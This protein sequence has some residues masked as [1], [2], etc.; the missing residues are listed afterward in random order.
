MNQKVLKWKLEEWLLFALD[1]AKYVYR[2]AKIYNENKDYEWITLNVWMHDYV[3]EWK[4]PLYYLSIDSL[5]FAERHFNM[6]LI[7]NSKLPYFS[8]W[9]I[10]GLL[11]FYHKIC[12][13][14]WCPG[15]HRSNLHSRILLY[16]KKIK[17][18]ENNENIEDNASQDHEMLNTMEAT[19]D[20]CYSPWKRVENA[21]LFF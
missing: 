21:K 8:F 18:S 14:E 15:N 13:N 1:Y 10:I 19:T 6:T 2:N 5:K 20:F 4:I 12:I 11:A 16:T 9:Q 3:S 7:M 17:I